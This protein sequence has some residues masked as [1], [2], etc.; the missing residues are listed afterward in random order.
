MKLRH[1]RAPWRQWPLAQLRFCRCG[2][3]L[4]AILVAGCAHSPRDG[5]RAAGFEAIPAPMPP[6]FLNGPMALLLTNAEG[7]R[8]QVVLTGGAAT[9]AKPLAV[10]ELMGRGGKLLF[11]P[12]VGSAASKK[13]HAGDS[14]F[15]WDVKANRG[16][17]LND[18]LQ[19]Y[20]P[21][22]SHRYYTNLAAGAIQANPAP[23]RIAGHRCARAEV[24][25]TAN[26]GAA[27]AFQVWRAEDLNGL[28]L[29]I[30]SV[31]NDVPITLTFSTIRREQVPDDLFQ[32]PNGFTKYESPEA[33]MTELALRKVNLGRK[34]TYQPVESD[35]GADWNAPAPKRLN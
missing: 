15:I 1:Q 34:T 23:E 33:M 16:W 11:A 9:Q 26:D 18:P 31:V 12:A 27:T 8:A 7:F 35:P 24:T 2:F 22:S 13:A 4:I 29:R 28:P 3:L 20:A 5:N 17:V 19:G 21:V 25:V 32:P 10:G 14:A 30:T 6:L